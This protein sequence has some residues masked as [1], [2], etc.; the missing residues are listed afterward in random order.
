MPDGAAAAIAAIFHY[1]A[2]LAADVLLML[3][4]RFSCRF[5]SHFADAILLPLL[6]AVAFFAARATQRCARAKE[7]AMI[8]DHI[9]DI[10]TGR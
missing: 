6:G 2:A 4:L 5:A 9:F 3:L 8:C 1:I 10:T 7:C